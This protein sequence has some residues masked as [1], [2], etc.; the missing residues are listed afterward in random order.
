M[1]KPQDRIPNDPR[2]ARAAAELAVMWHSKP[3]SWRVQ[4]DGSL[5]VILLSGPKINSRDAPLHFEPLSA[6]G[7]YESTA[8]IAEAPTNPARSRN[9]S[10]RRSA[11][12]DKRPTRR[13]RS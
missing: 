8:P 4:M 7:S 2:F 1:I 10:P 3:L 12:N 9:A 5:T 13:H 11:S 6:L